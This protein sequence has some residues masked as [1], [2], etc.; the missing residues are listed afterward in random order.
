MCGSES[1]REGWEKENRAEGARGEGWRETDEMCEIEGRGEAAAAARSSGSVRKKRVRGRDDKRHHVCTSRSHGTNE[2][3]DSSTHK[4]ACM[5]FFRVVFVLLAWHVWGVGGKGPPM[6]QA[7]ASFAHSPANATH[8]TSTPFGHLEALCEHP[9]HLWAGQ[10]R[11]S[12]LLVC[13]HGAMG[14]IGAFDKCAPPSSS[15]SPIAGSYV[16]GERGRQGHVIMPP[17]FPL[18][19]TPCLLPRVHHGATH[20]CARLGAT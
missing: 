10:Q 17:P 16:Q 15:P 5:F 8:S 9:R 11:L 6:G 13:L 14:P 4:C 2:D 3:K 12:Y 20:P 1:G 19:L 7:D 18:R